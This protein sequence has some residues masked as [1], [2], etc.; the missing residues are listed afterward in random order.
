MLKRLLVLVASIGLFALPM[1]AFAQTDPSF[2][3]ITNF[4]ARILVQTDRTVTVTED[5]A[6]DF[7]SNQK[8]GIYRIIPTKFTRNSATYNYRFTVDR[9]LMDGTPATFTESESGGNLTVK[10]GDAGTLVTGPHAYEITYHTNKAINFFN[11]E[12]ELYWNVTGNG[13]Q[14][15]IDAAS[16]VVTGPNGFD[17]VAARSMCFTGPFGSTEQSCTSDGSGDQLTIT[18]S[19]S[20]S[21]AEGLTFAVRFPKGMITPASFLE[22][23]WQI[24]RDNGILLLPL[25]VFGVMYYL[26]YTKGRDPKGRGSIIPQYEPPRGLSPAEMV[27]LTDEDVPSRGITA[28]IIDL[29]RRGYLS[30]EFGEEKGWMGSSRTY[31]FVEGKKADDMVNTAE[32]FVLDGLFVGTPRV[33]LHELKGSFYKTVTGAKTLVFSSL[34]SK[35]LI[36]ADPLKVKGAYMGFA[37]ALAFF[38]FWLLQSGVNG[39]FMVSMLVSAA[40]IGG[41]GW[42]MPRRTQEG[43]YADEEI[44]GFKWFLSVTEKQR[45][46]FTD[47]PERKPEQFHEFLGYAIAFGVEEK[48]A[49]QFAGIEIPPPSYA[50]G[51]MLVNWTA[52][53]FVHD[54]NTMHQVAAASAFAAPSSA[55]AGGSGFSGGGVGGGGGGGGG[56]SW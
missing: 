7:G 12:G 49:E 51:P 31:T 48:W 45:L 15:P 2:E 20:L 11:G 30:I 21:A 18:S 26:W 3:R 55:G 23:L 36:G 47:A 25:L 27:G 53:N 1:A 54:L 56:G 6:Y 5:I 22:T 24:V 28:T 4:S 9:V 19:R 35:G 8:H 16:A 44:K 46:A 37:G 14:V 42:F 33:E 52:M 50:H 39:M 40:I 38:S 43:A 34:K 10:I 41:F 32:Q 13:W 29:A 17:A